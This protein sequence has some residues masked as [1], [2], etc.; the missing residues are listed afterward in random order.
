MQEAGIYFQKAL[1]LD[2]SNFVIRG[3]LAVT[4]WRRGILTEA[5]ANLEEILK[6]KPG[7]KPT[8]LLLGMKDISHAAS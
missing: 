5:Q 2:P 1:Q 3:N 6:A 8:I 4:H 7:D